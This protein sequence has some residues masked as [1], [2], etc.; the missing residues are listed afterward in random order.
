MAP[1]A[2]APDAAMREQLLLKQKK[3]IELQQEKLRLE[4]LQTKA[5]L[6]EQQK[7]LEK[8]TG[9]LKPFSEKSQ[10]KKLKL[11]VLQTQAQ[12]EEQKKQLAK[13]T[14]DGSTP[15]RVSCAFF[16]WVYLNFYCVLFLKT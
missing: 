1:V 14:T 15:L 4:L 8:Q 7:M 11:D 16:K 9:H 6:E 5:Q 13:Q 3:L 2:L 12:L 10:K